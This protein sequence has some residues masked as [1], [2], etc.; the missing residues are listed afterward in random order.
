MFNIGSRKV[1]V[2]RHRTEQVDRVEPIST[3]TLTRAQIRNKSDGEKAAPAGQA[4][5]QR[6]HAF[7]GREDCTV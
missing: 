1:L 5:G 4:C 7:C 2:D 3:P 6:R